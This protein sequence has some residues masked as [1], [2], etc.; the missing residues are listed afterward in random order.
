[1][2]AK[3]VRKLDPGGPLDDNARRIVRRRLE[4]LEDLAVPAL[5]SG[6]ARE[7]HDMRIAAKRLRY[8]LELAKPALGPGVAGGIKTTKSLQ[9]LIGEIH[10]CDE[11]APRIRAHVRRLRRE[12]AEHLREVFTANGI[13]P[14]AAREI[15][16]R[17]RYRGLHTIL[18]EVNA[19]REVLVD[20]LRR[21]WTRIE[22]RNFGQE[23]LS[24]ISAP[25]P[26][27]PEPPAP[28]GEEAP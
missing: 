5:A 24:A 18:A 9:R 16:N 25:E 7:L 28:P 12:D 19:R 22:A 21:D 8:V 10:D 3:P 2:K 26:P 23:L 6:D 27:T 11:L 14:A 15:P 13:D 1:M 20:Q 4:E 17:V